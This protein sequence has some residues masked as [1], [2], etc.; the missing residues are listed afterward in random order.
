MS[1]YGYNPVNIAP[2]PYDAEVMWGVEGPALQAY[3]HFIDG[4]QQDGLFLGSQ[5]VT[6]F[7]IERV[8]QG[9]APTGLPYW[10]LRLLGPNSSV[11]PGSANA[12]ATYAD[13]YETFILIQ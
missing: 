10:T 11:P 3:H 13:E 5:G 2:Y 1:G 9:G 6:R 12:T 7:G 4:V 8:A